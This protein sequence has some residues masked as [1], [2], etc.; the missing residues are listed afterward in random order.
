MGINL[1]EIVG[2]AVV[3]AG[4][5][6]LFVSGV[7]T[8]VALGLIGGGA[9]LGG[10]S[11]V[12]DS[13]A[14]PGVSGGAQAPAP[15]PA[16]PTLPTTPITPPES[17]QLAD[18][19]ANEQKMIGNLQQAVTDMTADATRVASDLGNAQQEFSAALPILEQ[20]MDA[21][22]ASKNPTA[23]AQATQQYHELLTDHDTY[24]NDFI[25][26]ILGLLVNKY[27]A[28]PGAPG[29]T[30]GAPGTPSN[31]S[32]PGIPGTPSD[33]GILGMPGTPGTP[34]TPSDPG[35]LGMP[36]SF[37]GTGQIPGSGVQPAA[38]Q[39]PNGTSTQ[40]Q[41]ASAATPSSDGGMGNIASDLMPLEMMSMMGGMGGMG[42]QNMPMQTQPTTPTPAPLPSYIPPQGTGID[43]SGVNASGGGASG[44]GAGG[45]GRTQS[46]SNDN[47]SGTQPASS[48][49]SGGNAVPAG[50]KNEVTLPDGT[51]TR[52]PNAQAASAAQAALKGATPDDAYQQAGITLPPAGTPVV[53]PIA[54]G[55]LQPGDIGVWK[56]H[57]VMAL[58]DNKVLVNGQVQPASSLFNDGSSPDDFFG[59]I[60]PTQQSPA[61]PT[62]PPP[63]SVSAP[64]APS[65]PGAPGAGMPLSVTTG[66]PS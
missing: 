58:G 21:A 38:A 61:Q 8:P 35:I 55:D 16:A 25:V 59:W 33:P 26:A 53:N 57:H 65:A 48:A 3:G 27:N 11:K 22:Y 44:N 7:G 13:G 49:T 17:G 28:V 60:R 2:A 24:T 51:T 1:G 46:V 39:N 54:P 41:L 45:G 20:N 5:A 52:A 47:D 40:P 19:R 23:I 34:G 12:M 29:G 15:P 56:D 10:V 64:A 63:T 50:S 30:P 37:P 9:L 4:I 18:A 42:R 36:G 62:A 14:I 31:A 66:A 43:P 6:G 32:N